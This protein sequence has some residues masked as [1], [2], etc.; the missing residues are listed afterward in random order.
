VDKGAAGT[1]VPS[2]D[3]DAQVRS[4]PVD[5]GADEVVAGVTPPPP[6]KPVLGLLDNFNRNGVL[7]LGNNWQSLLLNINSNQANG[8]GFGSGY[9]NGIGAVFGAKQAAA[10]TFTNTPQNNTSLFLKGSGGFGLGNYASA[11]R[12]RLSGANVLVE[13]TANA[14]AYT[15]VATLPATF[16]SGDTLTAQVNA[17]GRVDVWKTTAANVTTHLGTG[18]TT[19][20]GTG[21]IGMQ[22]PNGARVDNFAGGTVP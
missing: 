5:V 7:N 2:N 11:I 6:V 10:F 15:V 14:V 19:F 12:V 3:Y 17:S 13:T 1:G 8:L 18:Q 4:S 21:R 9:W 20:T 16:V 22:L